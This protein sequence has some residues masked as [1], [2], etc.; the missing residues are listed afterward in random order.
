MTQI[1]GCTHGQ[2]PTSCPYCRIAK[3]EGHRDQWRRRAWHYE[4][5][6]AQIHSMAITHEQQDRTGGMAKL[7][8]MLRETLADRDAERHG[9][10]GK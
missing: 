7:A 5:R 3:L 4:D 1:M 10:D 9:K 6:I 2:E 8:E